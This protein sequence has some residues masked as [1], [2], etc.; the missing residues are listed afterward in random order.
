MGPRP[1]LFAFT[2]SFATLLFVVVAYFAVLVFALGDIP[3][4]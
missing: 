1:L 2:V 4:D 3:F